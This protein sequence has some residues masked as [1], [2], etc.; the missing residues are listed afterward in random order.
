MLNNQHKT[1][2][3]NAESVGGEF[4]IYD[5]QERRFYYADAYS[6]ELNIWVEF[7]ESY[8]TANNKIIQEDKF[9][10]ERIEDILKCTFIRIQT[11]DIQLITYKENI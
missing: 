11:S 2:F 4:R 7:D 1:I 8:H 9:R 10:Q 3:I 6:K 5:K